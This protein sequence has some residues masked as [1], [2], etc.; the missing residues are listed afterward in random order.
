MFDFYNG[1]EWKFARTWSINMQLPP[2]QQLLQERQ[3]LLLSTRPHADR[4][5]LLKHG[6]PLLS[7][8]ST[9][10]PN[11]PQTQQK[12]Q[13]SI[14]DATGTQRPHARLS[15]SQHP[16]RQLDCSRTWSRQHEQSTDVFVGLSLK[17]AKIRDSQG[18]IR[19]FSLR[20]QAD[21]EWERGGCISQTF[22][23]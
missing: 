11:L 14:A 4:Q 21:A 2:S 15:S 16:S 19:Y 7:T 10:T 8:Q 12:T 13:N 17:K 3:S 20:H 1:K 5:F 22:S 18:S 23:Q 9:L 6:R